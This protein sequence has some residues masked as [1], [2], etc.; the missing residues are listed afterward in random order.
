M[1]NFTTIAV[2]IV[3]ISTI[4]FSLPVDIT[5]TDYADTPISNSTGDMVY[6]G[7]CLWVSTGNGLSRTCDGGITWETFL[8]GKSF[9]AIIYGYDRI[10]A[11]ASFDTESA[12][13]IF[14]VGDG[15]HWTFIGESISFERLA[16]WQ[17]TFIDDTSFYAL[18]SYDLCI[19]PTETDTIMYSAN[20]Y[21]GLS[22]SKDWG[23]TWDNISWVYDVS[24]SGAVNWIVI[25][26]IKD[27]IKFFVKYL[28]Y[29]ELF[30]AVCADTAVEPPIIFTGTASGI[31]VVQDTQFTRVLPDDGLLGGWCV[32]LAV[33]YLDT[34]ERI[35][36]AASRS[37]ASGEGDGIC[38]ST[39]DGITWDTLSADTVQTYVD[40][41]LCIEYIPL[42]VMCWNF[43]FCG[44]TAFFACEQGFYR[45]A[46]LDLAEKIDI[47]DFQTGIEL[48]LDQMISVEVVGDTVWI[49]SD[50]GIAY[51][52]DGCACEN[53]RVLLHRP[54]PEENKT[55]AFPSPFSPYEHGTVFFVFDNPAKGDVS[56]SI[57]DFALDEFY[58]STE[59]VDAGDKQMIQWDG[60]DSD[61][62]YPA[63]GIYHFRITLPDGQELWGKFA[64]IR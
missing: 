28:G 55:Y 6:D 34:G 36:W 41:T 19:V 49:G 12:G 24:D 1:K 42:Y 16:P 27:S 30:F 23:E 32:A 54:Q 8:P 47:V 58:S 5:N 7:E 29:D 11:A 20:W 57:F 50:F 53:F 63:N 26:E 61:G 17:M 4:L 48:P 45:S 18:L 44:D 38:F 40:D 46:G 15:L 39:D 56:L 51:S 43:D 64:V 60:K 22:R 3:F 37:S 62:E 2:S 52:T 9:S 21:G 25:P 10:F 13:E 59:Y 14:P 35:I 33:Q 31:F